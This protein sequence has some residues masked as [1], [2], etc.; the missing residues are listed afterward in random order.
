MVLTMDAKFSEFT[1]GYA[2]IREAESGLGTIYEQTKAPLLPSLIAEKDLGWDVS[3]A[4]VDYALF[5][6]FKRASFV[7]RRHINS[8]TW[9][10]HNAPH[11]RYSIDTDGHQHRALLALEATLLTVPGSGDV[12]YTSP[13]FHKQEELDR[14]YS[15]GGVLKNS[16]MVSPS[17]LG[18]SDGV[19]HHTAVGPGA[20]VIMSEPRAAESVATWDILESQT[21]LRADRASNRNPT[22]RLRV[23]DLEEALRNSVMQLDRNID[24]DQEAGVL[25]KLHRSAAL[26]GCGLAL[27]VLNPVDFPD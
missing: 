13:V 4:F 5:L 27:F 11:Y 6:Q 24:I 26:L 1:Y 19:H 20:A 3:L 8:P 12:F 2:A 14:F 9:P 10:G 25:Q 18:D 23:L 7:S 17:A 15:T 22:E 21:R 16:S